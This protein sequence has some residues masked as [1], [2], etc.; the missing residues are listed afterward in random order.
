[1][2]HETDIVTA[3]KIIGAALD[4][5]A[6]PDVTTPTSVMEAHDEA[7]LESEVTS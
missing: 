5:L 2:D 6:D 3:A 1:M 4:R 7:I